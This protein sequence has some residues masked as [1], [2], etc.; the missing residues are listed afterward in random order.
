[1]FTKMTAVQGDS[2][3]EPLVLLSDKMNRHLI[4]TRI[5][6]KYGFKTISD[7]TEKENSHR[8]A[9]VNDAKQNNMRRLK[10]GK[11]NAKFR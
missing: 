10:I 7:G 8:A 1:M 3:K 2:E 5:S 11:Y 4:P 9:T 6:S